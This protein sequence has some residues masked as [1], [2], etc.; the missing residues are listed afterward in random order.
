VSPWGDLRRSVGSLE[1]DAA[2]RVVAAAADIALIVDGDG[3]IRDVFTSNRQ[4]GDV[5]D[6]EWQGQRWVETVTIESRPKVEE[7]LRVATTSEPIVWREINHAS[8]RAGQLPIRYSAV[9][10][11]GAGTILA[12]GRD[13]ST[14]ASLQQQ[15]LD[16]Q[17]SVEQE[18]AR[19]RQAEA[20][21]RLLF[22]LSDEAVVI[23]DAE[24]RR[25]L[26]ANPAS[27]RAFG[28]DPSRLL[29]RGL[30]D[31]VDPEV[32][33]AIE[34]GLSAARASS[35]S[36]PTTVRLPGGSYGMSLTQFRHDGRAHVLVRL[37]APGAAAPRAH[38]RTARLIE[39]LP[40]AFI[41]T[42]RDRRI[43]EAN[44]AFL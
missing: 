38:E 29:G 11:G 28:V 18:Y 15:V 24:T 42:D 33:P 34:A 39:Q 26:D 8:R 31:V 32:V 41:V 9:G 5:A 2:A 3:R 6:G 13:L 30:L 19:L 17:R 23:V 21:Y 36:D 43:L 4:L 27:G 37:V 12:I 25:I 35:R 7:L 44:A 10:V 14:I 20:R 1:P 22:Q 40:D 16:T